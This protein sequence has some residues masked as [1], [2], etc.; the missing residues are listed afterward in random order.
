MKYKIISAD[1]VKNLVEFLD[2][3]QFEA[4]KINTTDAHH[5][6]NFCTWAINE[7]L[8]SYD[9]FLRS[10]DKPNSKKSRQDYVDETFLD[11][12]LPDMSDEEYNKLIDQVDGFLRGW[13][14]E[15]LKKNPKKQTEQKPYTPRLDDVVEH[16]SL[17]E[18]QE[19]LND[20]PELSDYERFELYYEEHRSIEKS[21][22]SKSLKESLKK[23]GLKKP[24]NNNQ[25]PKK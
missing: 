2:E 15:Y 16:C 12:N 5:Q 3:I 22:E 1:T 14:K 4:A 17:E 24:P 19:F 13:E 6:V 11:W 21:K 7:L 10:K 25:T 20:D 18:I 23:A 9:A 8:N